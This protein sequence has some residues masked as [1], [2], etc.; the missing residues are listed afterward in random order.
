MQNILSENGRICILLKCTW[1]S[2]ARPY[3]RPQKSL[4]KFRNIKVLSNIFPD[5]NGMKVEINNKKK[6]KRCMNTWK[7][8]KTLEQAMDQRN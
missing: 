2:Q 4:N 8:N 6:S 1:N 5:L 3:V 7:L